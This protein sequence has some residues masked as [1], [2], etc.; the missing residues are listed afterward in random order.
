MNVV[1]DI[2]LPLFYLL[3][4]LA[5]IGKLHY[6]KNSGF[7]S[8]SLSFAFILK[9]FAGFFVYV[10]YSQYYP[11]RLEADTFRYFD[12]SKIMFESIQHSPLDFLKML[13]GI[14]CNTEE[15]NIEYFN[16]MYNWFRPY[17]DGLFNDNRLIIRINAFIRIF[18]FG[19]YHV[20]SIFFNFLSFLGLVELGKFFLKQRFSK[21]AVYFVLF[22]IPSFVFW[23]SG[24]LKETILVAILGVFLHQLYRVS[25]EKYN[26][27]AILIVLTCFFLLAI[28]K[29]YVLVSFVP[30]VVFLLVRN[31]PW[32]IFGNT[33][34]PLVFSLVLFS[35]FSLFPLGIDPIKIIV[36]KQHNFIALAEFLDAQSKIDIPYLREN[37][38]SFLSATPSAFVNTLLR[39]FPW[40][41]HSVI[42]LLPFL[43]NVLFILLIGMI[44]YTRKTMLDSFIDKKMVFQ[45]MVV[46]VFLFIIIGLTTPVI[47][48]IVRYKVPALPFLYLVVVEQIHFN[49]LR[50]LSKTR[51]WLLSK[52]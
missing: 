22:L 52:L 28:L 13:T 10:I 30:L 38:G 48:A 17:D 3:F 40:D 43:E 9:V 49:A 15:F 18:S 11:N 42:I 31:Q 26:P 16:R 25:V 1:L 35:I 7:S 5:L 20:H 4:L 36:T 12:D 27:L 39:P 24:I 8:L 33:Y 6:F 32:P 23:S 14:G 29:I 41:I 45:F 21:G 47:G 50:P 2:L 46:V 51:S 44:L 19:N 37:I 34:F